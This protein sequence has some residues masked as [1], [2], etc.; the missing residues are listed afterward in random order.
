[1]IG[2][3]MLNRLLFITEPEIVTAQ[4]EWSGR[5]QCDTCRTGGVARSGN[6]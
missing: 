3:T 4:R 2:P 5:D 1:M 6:A